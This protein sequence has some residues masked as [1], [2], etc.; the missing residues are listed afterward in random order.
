M[1]TVRPV[2]PT[3]G[4][5]SVSP[6][7]PFGPAYFADPYPVFD[8]LRGHSPAYWSERLRRWVLTRYDDVVSALRDTDTYSSHVIP[9][10]PPAEGAPDLSDF[11]TWSS[12]WLFFLDPPA[13][14]AQRSPVAR[15]LSARAVAD[16]EEQIRADARRLLDAATS[17]AG[18]IDLLADYAHPLA[19]GVIAGLL[20]EPGGETDAFLARCRAMEA[21]GIDARDPVARHRGLVAIAESTAH[22]KDRLVG[23]GP[24][25]R[26]PDHL[27]DAPGHPDDETVGAHSLVLLFAGVETTQNLIANAAYALLRHPDQWSALRRD[28]SLVPSAVEEAARY[29]LPVLGVLRRAT[30]DV[31][32]RGQQINS[33]DEIVVMVAA[34]NRDADQ[35]AY[36]HRFDVRRSPNPHLAF[37]LGP[38][39]CPGAAL[40]RLTTQIALAELLDRCPRL[41]LAT[42]DISWRD[43][44][45]IVRGLKRLPVSTR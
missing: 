44:D 13:H 39:Y 45:P 2:D 25:P 20:A 4:Q 17:G 43:H 24:L 37:G 31:R 3:I 16:I 21:A 30:R 1:P 29:A 28:P 14:T 7:D 19:A 26:F 34:A 41:E 6:P 23:A 36:P 42:T 18:E 8:H 27:R 10:I 40:T 11:V 12:R 22:L 38:H 9:R 5:L 35:F 33:G 32:M 15:A